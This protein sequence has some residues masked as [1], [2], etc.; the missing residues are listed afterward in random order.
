[1]K[2]QLSKLALALGAVV[3]TGNVMAA[4]NATATVS[5][6]VLEPIAISV[7]KDMVLG[8]L[9][10]GN[11]DVT[12]STSGQRTKSGST[13]LVTSTGVQAA[14]FAV[15]G[16]SG[17]TYSI[18]YTDSSAELS[19]GGVTPSV[20]PIAFI[21]EVGT[22]AGN[23]TATDSNAASGTLTDG[24]QKIFAGAKVTVG[25]SQPAGAYSGS[26]KVTVAYN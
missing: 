2:Q 22:T 7:S 18:S 6:T 9:V 23:K 16:A 11:G 8:N 21:T 14:E 13:A 1:M 19:T 10:A 17:A 12:L 4:D 3:M 20:M 5:A 25:A 24:S 26:L 15:T